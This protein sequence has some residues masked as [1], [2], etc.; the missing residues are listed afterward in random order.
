MNFRRLFITIN[1][2]FSLCLIYGCSCSKSL[3]DIHH[4]NAHSHWI[5]GKVIKKEVVKKSNYSN[6]QFSVQVLDILKGEIKSD[7]IWVESPAFGSACGENFEPSNQSLY[8]FI[9]KRDNR[10]YTDICCLN[11]HEDNVSKHYKD[12]I[13][14]YKSGGKKVWTNVFGDAIA[15]G[16]VINQKPTGTWIE[17]EEWGKSR[18]EVGRY[19][20]GKKEGKWIIYRYDNK[21]ALWTES[22]TETYHDGKRI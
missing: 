14:N 19:Q 7:I 20:N 17:Y 5:K 21:E 4:I 15:I 9:Q 16:E 3:V 11:S 10:Y 6:N 1:L 13:H 18:K 8:L 22:K 12:L 2:L